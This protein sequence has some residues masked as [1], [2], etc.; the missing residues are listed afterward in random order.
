MLEQPPGCSGCYNPVVTA[1]K[2]ARSPC[3][4]YLPTEICQEN[5]YEQLDFKHLFSQVCKKVL[6]L[7]VTI[8]HWRTPGPREAR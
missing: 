3:L 5:V 1:L 4:H 7:L 8:Q 2:S 6:T